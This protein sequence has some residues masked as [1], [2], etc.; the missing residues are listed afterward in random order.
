M[1]PMAAPN[2]WLNGITGDLRA[3]RQ[4][5][6]HGHG[7]TARLVEVQKKRRGGYNSRTS[8]SLSQL[9]FNQKRCSQKHK[10]QYR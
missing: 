4:G 2:S 1:N 10:R 6:E 9:P 5:S 8:F 7:R 3:A